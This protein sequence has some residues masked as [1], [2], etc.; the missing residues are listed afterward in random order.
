MR[1]I[2][3]LEESFQELR[4][5]PVYFVPRFISTGISTAWFIYILSNLK[6]NLYLATAPFIIFMGL[7]VPVMVAY[8]VENRSGLIEGFQTTLRKAD[9]IFLSTLV[10]FAAA[11]VAALPTVL[12]TALYIMNRNIAGLVIGGSLSLLLILATGFAT[13]FLPIT[14]IRNGVIESFR[15]SASFSSQNSREVTALLLFS[16]LLF[17]LSAASSGVLQTLGLIGFVLGRFTSAV[18][19][20]Y[21]I[22]VSPKYYLEKGKDKEN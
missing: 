10:F 18:V 22:V 1:L 14:L 15:E 5:R 7:F 6:T 17:G 20:T 19:A 21:L 8:M 13:Y 3:I 4:E 2:E 11:A 9:D 12:G 16:F